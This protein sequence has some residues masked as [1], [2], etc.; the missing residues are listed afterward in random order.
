MGE[1]HQESTKM[2]SFKEW[3]ESL[4][5]EDPTMPEYWVKAKQFITREPRM[6]KEYAKLVGLSPE[7]IMQVS[8]EQLA[9]FAK[10]F[11]NEF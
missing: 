8:P 6:A 9:D 7:K 1:V 5:S 11:Q 4:E 3:A 2:K 10:H